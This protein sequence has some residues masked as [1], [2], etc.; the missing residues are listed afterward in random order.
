MSASAGKGCTVA[1]TPAHRLRVGQ[2]LIHAITTAP[3]PFARSALRTSASSGSRLV[4]IHT[5]NAVGCHT[6][7]SHATS[8]T[9]SSSTLRVP[10]RLVRPV[11][12][13]GILSNRPKS[14]QFAATSK[15]RTRVCTAPQSHPAAQCIA[16][17][18]NMGCPGPRRVVCR[19]AAPE[20][21]RTTGAHR[22]CPSSP[23]PWP[24]CQPAHAALTSCHNQG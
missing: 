3:Q 18:A 5:S 1:R 9:L 7:L 23:F 13:I 10:G 11:T 12:T 14:K 22:W 4:A 8:H 2:K 19:P 6:K 17:L 15:L 20:G 21:P 24:V 16:K